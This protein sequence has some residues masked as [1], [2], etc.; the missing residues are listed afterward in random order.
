MFTFRQSRAFV[1][2]MLLSAALLCGAEALAEVKTGN[3]HPGNSS[4]VRFPNANYTLT[5]WQEGRQVLQN[6]GTGQIAL[7]RDFVEKTVTIASIQGQ[8][9]V[10]TVFS[11]GVSLCRLQTHSGPRQ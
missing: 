6:Q 7:S 2:P 4:T 11:T 9:P 8:G 10:V 5:C 1:A 3:L